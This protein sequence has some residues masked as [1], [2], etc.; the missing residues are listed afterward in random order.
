MILKILTTPFK[1]LIWIW[2]TSWI[3]ILQWSRR[4]R[5][6]ASLKMCNSNKNQAVTDDVFS[7]AEIINKSQ[8]VNH[9]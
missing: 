9:N 1:M 5:I 4:R 6:I 3:C 8:F 7:E 2:Q